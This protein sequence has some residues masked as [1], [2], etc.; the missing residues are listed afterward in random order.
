M[1]PRYMSQMLLEQIIYLINGKLSRFF[2]IYDSL[3]S[4]NYK[5][6]CKQVLTNKTVLRNLIPLNST[7]I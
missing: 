3:I 4:S 2:Y 5:R 6:N 1:D 7:K